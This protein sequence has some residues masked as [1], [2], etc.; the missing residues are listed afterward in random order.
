MNENISNSD[1][2]TDKRFLRTYSETVKILKILKEENSYN[3]NLIIN[4]ENE[5][6]KIHIKLN[7]YKKSKKQIIISIF[8][9]I[10]GLTFGKAL[11]FFY[12]IFIIGFILL[13]SS[14][15][16]IRTNKIS[17]EKIKYIEN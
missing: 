9:I 8:L 13:I 3:Q 7:T 5:D 16:G 12:F 11:P 2:L 15:W 4:V 6:A 14:F 10:L 1:F 17:K